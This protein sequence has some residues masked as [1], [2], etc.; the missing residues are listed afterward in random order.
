MTMISILH[1]IA[2]LNNGG[3][4]SGD[5][6]CGVDQ[7][8][9]GDWHRCLFEP[10]TS[11]IGEPTF[12][13]LIGIGIYGSMYVAGGG[14]MTT[15]TVVTILLATLMFPLLPGGFSGIAWAVLLVGAA[16]S[17]LQVMQ[18]YVLSPATT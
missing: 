6:S 15:P 12:G 16:G 2:Q 4:Y 8:I 9:L 7:W 13:V 3:G 11:L 5:T 14:D 17:I 18:K 1:T 10:I